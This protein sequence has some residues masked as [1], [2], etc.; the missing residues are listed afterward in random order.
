MSPRATWRGTL[1]VG[2]LACPVA[3]FAAASTSERVA[4]HMVNRKTGHRLSRQF[5][6]SETG[7]PVDR[8]DQVKGYETNSNDYVVFEPDELASVI[9]EGDKMLDIDGF[10]PCEAVDT[11]YFDRPYY[12]APGN[13]AAKETFGLVATA[14]QRE[15]VAALAH[16]VLFRRHR[17][18][19]LRAHGSGLYA[20]T[21]NFDYEV[22][23]AKDAFSDITDVKLEDEMME[24]AEHIIGKKAGRFDPTG[25]DDRYD[26][27]LAE[28][29]K[30]K[31]EGRKIEAPKPKRD[32][33]VIDL[34]AALRESAGSN[35]GR[36]RTAKKTAAKAKSARSKAKTGT[37][38]TRR[39]AS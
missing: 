24:L 7:K 5:V 2:E 11:I 28:L 13:D 29:V 35:D 34:M 23:S 8:D 12:I 17:T 3:L 14:M 22:R 33:K 31:I 4:F 30:A 15:K 16:A 39:K 36:K 19:I 9:P 38:T 20:N 6:D 1:K 27:A 32:E 18:V 26:A 37:G 21:L 25:F 10:I